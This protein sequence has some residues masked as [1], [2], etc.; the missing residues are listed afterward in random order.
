[1]TGPYLN[2]DPEVHK[3]IRSWFEDIQNNPGKRAGLRRCQ[4]LDEIFFCQGYWDLFYRI[5]SVRENGLGNEQKKSL[6]VLAGNLAL[7]REWQAGTYSLG[8]CLANPGDRVKALS[9]LRF[10]RLLTHHDVADLFIPLRR[11][12]SLIRFHFPTLALAEGLLNWSENTRKKW[13]VDYYQNLPK[14]N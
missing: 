12:I 1:M 8:K 11:A 13:A 4:K 3:A 14:S 5:C 9:P 6:A 7:C 10:R 2:Q